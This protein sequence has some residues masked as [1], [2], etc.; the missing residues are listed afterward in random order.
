MNCKVCGTQYYLCVEPTSEFGAPYSG[1]ICE[2]CWG[3]SEDNKEVA[4]MLKI[5]M[6]D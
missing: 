2:E 3:E 5:L 1:V 4:L 6:L